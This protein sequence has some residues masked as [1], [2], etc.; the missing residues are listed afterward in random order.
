MFT[1]SQATRKGIKPLIGLY[2]L[3]NSGKTF[4]ALLMA[5]GFAGEAGKVILGDTESG[6]GAL[7]AD[8]IP[9]GFI[10]CDIEPPFSPAR[11][12]EFL[13]AAEKEKPDIIVIDSFSHEWE[14]E[15]GVL[16]LAEKSAEQRAAKRGDHWDG[17]VQFGDWKTPK[18]D[19]AKLVLRLLRSKVPVIV[20]LRAKFKSR[21]VKGQNNRSEIVRDDFAT[22][23]QDEGFIFELTAHAEMQTSNPGTIHLTK[24]SVPDLKECFPADNDKRLGIETGRKIREWADGGGSPAVQ[25]GPQSKPKSDALL[26]LLTKVKDATEAAELTPLVDEYKGLEPDEQKTAREAISKRADALHLVWDKVNK[27]FIS[28]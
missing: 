7:Y 14:G 25:V 23:I 21:Q 22:P 2:G 24:W 10:R 20:C 19:H 9:G 1:F 26:D 17:R 6:R 13:D 3:S 12:I 5:R 11:Y 28:E 15:G 27:Q 18:L 8:L 4:S 16:D